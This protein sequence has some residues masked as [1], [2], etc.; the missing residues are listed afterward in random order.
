MT[1]QLNYQLLL[2]D[3]QITF[4]SHKIDLDSKVL[5]ACSAFTRYYSLKNIKQ[6]GGVAQ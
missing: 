6:L 1:Q 4:T 5:A 2:E 3:L